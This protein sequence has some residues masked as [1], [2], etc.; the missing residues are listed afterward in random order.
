MAIQKSHIWLF[1]P[2]AYCPFS[3]SIFLLE[4]PDVTHTKVVNFPTDMWRQRR[5]C[6][7]AQYQINA[8]WAML[9]VIFQ[10]ICY[11]YFFLL[12]L[13]VIILHAR[14]KNIRNYK[15][16]LRQYLCPTPFC[17]LKSHC[18]RW[19]RWA[20]NISS[21][22]LGFYTSWECCSHQGEVLNIWQSKIIKA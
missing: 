7:T 17:F 22:S 16:I 13:S 11:H 8:C 6:K 3:T 15:N 4:L 9:I 12:S 18:H 21:D 20:K 1:L 5:S 10:E 14:W 19:V 2:S